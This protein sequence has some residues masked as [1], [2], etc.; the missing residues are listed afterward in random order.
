MGLHA[1]AHCGA[2]LLSRTTHP[3]FPISLVVGTFNG[4]V[5]KLDYITSMG[6]DAIWISPI[7]VNTPG[8]YRA[9]RR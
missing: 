1:V 9:C 8:G 4:I 3:N 7:V 6:F 2:I 5:D